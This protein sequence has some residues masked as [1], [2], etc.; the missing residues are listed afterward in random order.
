MDE[1]EEVDLPEEYA[2]ERNWSAERVRE[3][4]SRDKEDA[5]GDRGAERCQ[6][7]SLQVEIGHLGPDR[8]DP[9]PEVD[10]K[11]GVLEFLI[12]EMEDS[13]LVLTSLRH[14]YAV[15]RTINTVNDKEEHFCWS[16]GQDLNLRHSG[17]CGL[18]G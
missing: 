8:G 15:E 13:D 7:L 16:R 17:S 1:V 11:M 3:R 4:V 2:D 12:D 18:D 9:H 10:G 14:P 5:A 6:I